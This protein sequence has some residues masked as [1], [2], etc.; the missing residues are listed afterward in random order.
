VQRDTFDYDKLYMHLVGS[1][2][3]IEVNEAF[4]G[5][6]L[7]SCAPV[8]CMHG[9]NIQE[10]FDD[11]KIKCF[12]TASQQTG[13]AQESFAGSKAPSSQPSINPGNAF[14]VRAAYAHKRFNR[15]T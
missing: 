12:Q 14:K 2:K 15:F 7:E 9:L 5:D 1:G 11:K 4:V 8:G 3:R 13:A 6:K 10:Y